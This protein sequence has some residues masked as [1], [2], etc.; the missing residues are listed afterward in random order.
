MARQV[1][2]WGLRR[3]REWLGAMGWRADRHG[4][5]LSQAARVELCVQKNTI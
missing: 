3:A 1:S 5:F 2:A 4:A